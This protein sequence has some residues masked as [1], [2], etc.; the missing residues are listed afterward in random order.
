MWPVR[1]NPECDTETKWLREPIPSVACFSKNIVSNGWWRLKSVY[2]HPK[3]RIF[4]NNF[5]ERYI[6]NLQKLEN[7]DKT[8]PK[9]ASVEHVGLPLG[10]HEVT[11]KSLEEERK[12]EYQDFVLKVV[13]K[14]QTFV[15][16]CFSSI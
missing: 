14:I 8:K 6:H 2:S 15:S 1:V 12:A 10:T 5:N 3:R 9:A 4:R 7:D 13:V 11:R 16:R